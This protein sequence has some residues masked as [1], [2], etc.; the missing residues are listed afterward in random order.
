MGDD[1]WDSELRNDFSAQRFSFAAGSGPGSSAAQIG[2]AITS[3]KL[4]LRFSRKSPAVLSGSQAQA[5][6]R[7]EP[8]GIDPTSKTRAVSSCEAVATRFPS[9]ENATAVTVPA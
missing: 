9:P 7:I 4:L 1:P 6:E 5:T 3:P 2:L 8:R